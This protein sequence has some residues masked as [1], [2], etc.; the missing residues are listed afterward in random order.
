M[1]QPLVALCQSGVKVKGAQLKNIT[2]NNLAKQL[3]T[4]ETGEKDGS[5]FL[6]TGIVNTE[7]GR[8]DANTQSTA[9]VLILDADSTTVNAETGETTEGAP[10]P[11]KVHEALKKAGTNHLIYRSYSHGIKGNRFRVVMKTDKPYS[12]V[13]LPATVDYA[14]SLCG[15][16]I[17]NVK[18]NCTWSQGWYL[19][20]KPPGDSSEFTT[21]SYTDGEPLSVQQPLPD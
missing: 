4:I 21:L 6:R 2:I 1:A 15:E 18:E 8:S 10:C 3:T 16:P 13:E 12:R 9:C 20:R 19:P 5:Y 14:L 17:A 7:I 11:Y